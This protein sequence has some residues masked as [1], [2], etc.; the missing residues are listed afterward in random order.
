MFKSYTLIALLLISVAPTCFGQWR[1]VYQ[2]DESGNKLQG[3][4]ADLRSAIR[5]GY[6]IRV[7]WGSQRENEPNISVEHVV[8]AKFLTIMGQKHVQAQIDPIYGQRPDFQEVQI[9]I[10]PNEWFMIANTNG[11][12]TT[13]T[14][15]LTTGE[16]ENERISQRKFT[17]YTTAP[18]KKN[19]DK[20]RL[21]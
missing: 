5:S 7:G 1:I 16:I 21:F 18:L 8:D 15:D 12:A 4:L 6:P 2:N 10:R 13:A 3:E 17:W 14:R 9:R 19:E 11:K 20:D